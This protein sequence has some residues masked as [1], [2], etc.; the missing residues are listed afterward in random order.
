MRSVLAYF[1]LA[2]CSAVLA[3][4]TPVT[5]SSVS[6][7]PA[8]GVANLNES[9]SI[10][11]PI[12]VLVEFDKLWQGELLS[13]PMDHKAAV[14]AQHVPAEI[15]EAVRS[16][17]EDF[18]HHGRPRALFQ[19]NPQNPQKL[20]WITPI[21]VQDSQIQISYKYAYK[22]QGSIKIGLGFWGPKLSLCSGPALNLRCNVM[23]KNGEGE[24]ST[25]FYIFWFY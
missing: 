4:P 2:L 22:S 13:T 14:V 7:A 1:T 20:E 8:T 24:N 5:T 16:V 25:T 19:N 18:V 6:L 15:G 11:T 21:P 12:S 3:V 23:L 9:P 10:S 17:V